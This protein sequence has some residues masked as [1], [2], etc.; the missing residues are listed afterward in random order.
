MIDFFFKFFW[1]KIKV[2]LTLGV[3]RLETRE[4]STL[5]MGISHSFWAS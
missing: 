2:I 4:K 1:P 3:R 5:E